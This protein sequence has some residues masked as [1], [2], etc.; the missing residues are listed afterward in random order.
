MPCRDEMRDSNLISSCLRERQHEWRVGLRAKKKKTKGPA[1]ERLLQFR[2]WSTLTRDGGLD[3]QS[4]SEAHWLSHRGTHWVRGH[5]REKKDGR[6]MLR[7]LVSNLAKQQQSSMMILL[8]LLSRLYS[9]PHQQP[10]SFFVLLSQ[11][12]VL[13]T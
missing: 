7:F 4:N 1:E 10:V 13:S 3:F 6:M 9:T 2:I 8:A 11:A 5:C 12:S